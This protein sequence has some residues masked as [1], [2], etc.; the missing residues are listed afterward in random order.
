MTRRATSIAAVIALVVAVAGVAWVAT[1]MGAGASRGVPLF[2]EEARSAGIEHR[3]EGEFEYF[4]GGGV[5]VL[6]CDA[7]GRPPAC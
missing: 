2:V 7:D 6:D 3:Y 4:V 1:G 5:A